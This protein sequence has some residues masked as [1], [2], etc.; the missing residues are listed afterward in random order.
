MKKGITITPKPLAGTIKIMPSKSMSHRMAICA[1][2][3]GGSQVR[4]LGLSEDITATCRVL[5]GLGCEMEL[6]GDT[7]TTGPKKEPPREAEPLDCGESGSTL[8]F[9]IPL[10]LDGKRRR[11]TGQGRLMSRP[12]A[13]YERIFTERGIDFIRSDDYIEVCGRLRPGVFEVRGDVSSQ[14]ISGLLFALPALDGD[15]RIVVTTPPESRGYIELT[16]SALA[17]VGIKAAWDDGGRALNV[18]GR[19]RFAPAAVTVEGDFSHAA[20]WLAAGAVGGGAELTGLKK[21][22]LQGDAMIVELARR[23]GAAVEWRGEKLCVARSKLR[24]A[25]IDVSQTPDLFPALSVLAAC[26]E[27]ETRLTGAARLRIKESDRLAAM[28]AEL[29][30]L[31][32]EVREGEDSLTITG[33]G[34][35]RGGAVSAHNDHRVAMSLA[36]AASACVG[37]TT[38]DDAEC[39]KKSAPDFWKEYRAMGGSF[40]IDKEGRQ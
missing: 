25:E 29:A 36:V 20:F 15:S 37:E 27:G 14:F 28:A 2:L 24:G 5:R 3:A 22:S 33:G 1:A 7:L 32:A 35:L 18:P 34:K 39:V 19:Q 40:M 9:I 30:A 11:F 31:G 6:T 8:R 23:M 21:D 38:I 13:E 10:A 4:S 16:L 26:A 17:G 12:Q